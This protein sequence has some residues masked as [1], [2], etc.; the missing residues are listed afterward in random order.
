MD[1]QLENT[2]LEQS[3]QKTQTSPVVIDKD[4]PYI[5]IEEM[6][7]TPEYDEYISNMDENQTQQIDWAKADIDKYG[8]EAMAN[9]AVSRPTIAADTFDPL[10]Q[11]VPPSANVPNS[12]ERL[13]EDSLGAG[14]AELNTPALP[15]QGVVQPIISGIRQS[16]FERYYNHPEY[17]RLG[18]SPYAN[19]EEYYNSNSTAAD[20]RTRMWEQ[21]WKLTGTGFV[22]SY[23]SIADI[24]GGT[25]FAPDLASANE[26][27]DA[28]RIGNSS[29]GGL[30]GSANNFFLNSGYTFGIIGSIA[31]EEIILA[32]AAAGQGF[33]NPAS[34]AALVA[35]TARNIG[36]LFSIPGKIMDATI[37][38]RAANQA[39][40][41][42]R[43]M[44]N[45]MRNTD[46][47]K[48]FYTA[49][50]SG[51]Q[52]M[53]KIFFPETTAAIRNIKT[54]QQ[55]A[56]NLTNMAK[57]SQ[58]FGGFYRDVRSFNYAL[59]ESKLEAGLVYNERIR[60]NIQIQLKKNFGQDVTAEQMDV[61]VKNA[62][63][64]SMNTLLR[65]APLIFLTNQLVLGT[66]FG[67][68]NKSFARM[69]NQNVSS[70][71]RRMIK[72]TRA[73]GKDGLP[74]K[75]GMNMSAKLG[76]RTNV[77]EGI[78]EDAGRGLKGLWNR[79]KNV[80]VKG[81]TRALGG[82]SLRYFS[83]NLAEGL[84][85]V[86]QEAISSG[87]NHYFSSVMKDPLA[88]GVA[89]HG[90]SVS[91]GIGEQ[92]SSQG[93]E[94]FMSGFLMGGF[95]QGPQ[96]LF[97]QGLP[98]IYNKA[99]G[100]WG[101]QEMKDDIAEQNKREDDYINA[102]IDH[103]NAAWNS[104]ID[105]PTALWSPENLAFFAQKE[106]KDDQIRSV[107]ENDEFGFTDI[108]DESK[109][110]QIFSILET[111]GISEQISQYEDFQKLS[112]ENLAEAF[113]SRV[114]DIKNGKLRKE[115]ADMVTQINKTEDK[116][117]ELKDRYPNPFSPGAFKKNSREWQ[118][119]ILKQRAW[120][121][122]TFLYMFT[123]DGFEK[124]LERYNKIYAELQSDPI[125]KNMSA[126]DISVLLDV[127]SIKKEI[128]V[129]NLEISTLSIDK[130]A[131]AEEIKKKQNKI[132]ALTNFKDLVTDKKNLT[133]KGVFNRTK[134]GKLRAVFSEY[135]KTLAS[136]Q[137]T[138]AD[139]AVIDSALQ[140]IVDYGAL[141]GRAKTYYKT[142]EYLNNPERFNEIVDRT[143]AIG[144][145]QFKA[146]KTEFERML[147]DYLEVNK[148]NGLL[149]SI[150]EEGVF[151]NSQFVEV[152]LETGEATILRLPNVFSNEEGPVNKQIQPELY[153]VVM[154][155]VNA[156]EATQKTKKTEK[157]E[158]EKTETDLN[159]ENRQ[160][161]NDML[162]E[163]GVDENL[164]PSDSELYNDRLK[165]VYQKYLR[166]QAIHKSIP[167]TYK[168]FVNTEQ[169]RNFRKAYNLSRA[170]FVAN[171]KLLYSQEKD[172]LTDD[173]IA[174][175]V[176]FINWLVSNEGKTNDL[177]EDVLIK[178]EVL[179]SDITGRTE[180]IGETVNGKSVI[181]SEKNYT[182]LKEINLDPDGNDIE[183][184]TIIDSETKEQISDDLL[185]E[186]LKI[187]SPN[188]EN[189]YI[190]GLENLEEANQVLELLEKEFGGVESFVYDGVDLNFGDIVYNKKKGLGYQVLSNNDSIV[191]RGLPLMLK[192]LNAEETII[193]PKKGEF[194]DYFT[195]QDLTLEDLADSVSRLNIND[196][197]SL[198]PNVNESENKQ[199]AVARLNAIL[200][201]LTDEEVNSL[202]MVVTLEREGAPVLTGK[203]IDL[204]S[205]DNEINPRIE[206]QYSKYKIG[207]KVDE[208]NLSVQEKINAVINLRGTNKVSSDGI[209]AFINVDGYQFGKDSKLDENGNIV[210]V[211]KPENFTEKELDNLLVFPA[212]MKTLNGQQK[213]A[214]AKKNFAMNEVLLTALD[215]KMKGE[216][217][218]Q[219]VEMDLVS[220]QEYLIS[221]GITFKIQSGGTNYNDSAR[222]LNEL[223]Y[224]FADEAGNFV[225]YRLDK[226]GNTRTP[227]FF[228]NLEGSAR[229]TLRD[230]I[231]KGLKDQL[232][233]D[234]MINGTAGTVAVVLQ[235]NGKYVLVNLIASQINTSALF[236][237]VIGKA[238]QV[239][240]QIPKGKNRLEKDSADLK[241]LTTWK[242]GN[243]SQLFITTNPNLTKP[244]E[245][246]YN[247]YLDI[248]PW[249]AIEL[250]LFLGTKHGGRKIST[251]AIKKDI[252]LN[253]E[254][255]NDMITQ[256]LLD[257]FNKDQ[258][259]AETGVTIALENF[260]MHSE[261]ND[262][263]VTI[264][265]STE[266]NVAKEVSNP[267][268]MRLFT[269]SSESQA[270]ENINEITTKAQ[271]TQPTSDVGT[272]LTAGGNQ[273]LEGLVAA[274]LMTPEGSL[275]NQTAE[276][277]AGKFALENSR[278][279][280]PTEGMTEAEIGG[281][282]VFN[283]VSQG[284][285]TMR[286]VEE[287]ITRQVLAL[288][289]VDLAKNITQSSLQ[290]LY[291]K[292]EAR[293]AVIKADESLT[294]KQKLKKAKNDPEVISLLKKIED[295]SKTANKIV[296]SMTPQ[297]VEDISVFI[298]WAAK[299][300]P[301]SITIQDIALLGN[302]LKTGGRRV[303][304]FVLDLNSLAGGVDVNGTIYTGAASPFRYH[305]AFHGVYRMLLT[306]AEQKKY[307]AVARK[308][309]RAKLRAEGKNF[310]TELEK[311]KN[312]ADTYTNMSEQE[313]KD[314]YYEEYMADEFEKFKANPRS[315]NT[316]SEVK[317]LFTR[318]LDWIK[319]V[320][321]SY[322]SKQLQ[323]LFENIDSGK[324]YNASTVINQFT[325][326]IGVTLEANA[327]VPYKTI[328]Q[329][330]TLDSKGNIV[331]PKRQ[332][333]LYLDSVIADPMI[334]SMA[335]MYL[336]R[337][338]NNTDPLLL[339]SD[340]LDDLIIDFQLLLDPL[341]SRNIDK[342]EE[343]K[344]LLMQ[345]YEAISNS[346]P[347]IESQV[348]AYLNVID[349]Q[350]EEEEYNKEF[351]EQS[352]GLR[353]TEQW[354]TDASMVGGINSSPK[355]VR[356]YLAS[357]TI[358]T[359]DF[360]GNEFLTEEV[361]AEGILVQEKLIIP[362]NFA[363][364][365][366][367]LLKS[368]KNIDD[369]KL[370]LR[371]MY[372][373]GLQNPETGAV[374]SR[375]L[376]D[377]G[378]SEE[379]ILK[380][381][382]L[383][384]EMNDPFLFNSLTKAFENFRVNYLFIQR[385]NNSG[386]VL[387]YSAAQRDDIN[388][389]IDRWSQAWTQAQK[390]LKSNEDA[391]NNIIKKLDSLQAAL[392]PNRTGRDLV[393]INNDAIDYSNKIFEFTG[394]KL[395]PQ[396]ITFSLLSNIKP[397]DIK[398]SDIQSAF[399]EVHSQ[400][401]PIER[402]AISEMITLI[403]N[404]SDIFS[405]GGD[406]MNSRLV[407]LAVNNAPFDERIGLSVFKNAE[408]NLVYAHQKPTFHLR[409]VERLNSP[410]RL[411]EL[412]EE[413]YLKNNYLLNNPAFIKMSEKS[414]HK[415][416]RLAGSAVGRINST[417]DDINDN[418]SGVAS[419][420][421]YGNY[422]VQE[423]V[424]SLI[425]S[426][427]E[428][429]NTKSGKVNFVE[430]MDDSGNKTKVALSPNLIRVL[431]ASNTGDLIYLPVI[432]AITS[433]SVLTDEVLNIFTESIKT[434]FDRI[435]R[436][437]SIKDDFNRRQIVGF[438]AEEFDSE[439]GDLKEQ[440]A[441]KLHNSA[442]L[443][444][445]STK[446][447]LEN[448]A[449]RNNATFDEALV[450]LQITPEQFKISLRDI[451]EDQFDEFRTELGD[452]NIIN[453]VSS[454]IIDGLQSGYNFENSAALLNL[455][456]DINHNLKQI[457]FNDWV[458]T[459]SINEILLGDEA[460]T[461]K[462]GV[463]AIKRA[464]AQNAAT[465][466]A[467]SAITSKAH[468]I[469]HVFDKISSFV[470]EE[471]QGVSSITGNSIDRADAILYNTLKGFRY[472]EFGFGNLT[473]MQVKLLDEIKNDGQRF[474][475]P[476]KYQD[477]SIFKSRKK[478]SSEEIFG[479]NGY[480]ANGA[481]INSRKLVYFDGKTFI[482]MSA[483]T[484]IPQFTSDNVETDP[485]KPPIWVAKPNRVELHN[486]RVKL[487]LEETENKT[488]A[489]AAPRTAFKMLKQ[490]VTP[491][492]ELNNPNKFINKPSELSAKNLGLQVAN[493]S[494][495]NEI[496]DPSQIKSLVT[497]EQPDSIKVPALRNPDGTAMTV[498]Q[499]RTAYNLATSR[500][501]VLK[502]KNKRNLIFTY[503]S[504][505]DELAL[506]KKTGKL[507]PN[508]LVFL[509]YAQGG[510][511]ASQA[512]SNLLEF[513]SDKNNE[514]QYDL[515]NPITINKFESLF[516]SYL[517]KG[518]L[519]EK[520][521][522][523]SLALISDFGNKVYRRVYEFDENGLP[524]RSEI[525]RDSV[526]KKFP[527]KIQEP[528]GRDSKG[529]PTWLQVEAPV[530]G[531]VIQDRLRTGVMEF[532]SN[533]EPTGE[534]HSEG[535]MPAHF[536]EVMDLIENSGLPMPDVISKMFAI[537]IPS[538]DNHST[539][540]VK[541]VDF[542]PAIYGS[543]GMF[544]QELIEISGADFDID[545]IY[546][547]IKEWYVKNKKFVEYGKATTDEGAYT[548]YIEYVNSKVNK[549]DSIY[550]Q[551]L[552]LPSAE[553]KNSLSDSELE[554][555]T[556]AGFSENSWKAL[557]IL[558]L[559]ITKKDYLEYR[560][561]KG[562]P[563]EA[564]MNNAILDYKYALMGHD[565][566]TT[567]QDGNQAISYTPASLTI[568]ENLWDKLSADSEYLR[569]RSRE[570]N[571][572]INNIFG[573]GR[574]F[575]ANKG[576]SI[577]AVVSPNQNLSLLTEYKI[578]INDDGPLITINGVTYNTFEHLREHLTKT[579]VGERKQDIISSLITM[580]TDNAKER[581]IAKF[582]LN[583]QA[584]AAV[585]NLTA[586]S[587]PIETSILLVNIPEM[588]N[589]YTEA[590]NKKEQTDPGVETLLNNRLLYLATYL[591]EQ[592]ATNQKNDLVKVSV[593]DELLKKYLDTP[594]PDLTVAEKDKT[595]KE[596]IAE[597][598]YNRDIYSILSTILN[599]T[600]ITK[601][602]G[603]MR[604]VS[605]LTSGLGKDIAA[606]NYKKEQIDL[607]FSESAIMDLSPIY[608]SDTWQ[609]TYL[610]IFNEIYR[611]VLPATFLSASPYFSQIISTLL[612][613]VNTE[614]SQFTSDQ[615]AKIE[616]DLLSY[617]TIKGYQ[618][619]KGDGGIASFANLNN[620]LIYPY[621]SDGAL[622]SE[623]SINDVIEN[624][625]NTQAGTNNFFLNVFAIQTPATQK[626]NFTGLN[627]VLSN[628]FRSLNGMQKVDLQTSFAELYG[629]IETKGWA[630]AIINYIM[631]KDGLQPA[632]GTLLDAI[633][634]YIISDYL[635]HIETT[636]DAMRD[637][638][639]DQKMMSTFGLTFEEMQKDFIN[640]YLSS[641]V[642][643]ALLNTFYRNDIST[644][645]GDGINE[646]NG[647]LT[648]NVEKNKNLIDVEF[649]RIQSSNIA[650]G[651]TSYNTYMLSEVGNNLTPS[652][653]LEIEPTG[654]NQQWGGGFMFGPRPSYKEVRKSVPLLHSD[655]K[656]P[657]ENRVAR[658]ATQ[659]TQD[660]QRR[661][662]DAE[663]IIVTVGTAEE[664]GTKVELKGEMPQSQ[665]FVF[666]PGAIV[667][668]VTQGESATETI[669]KLANNIKNID[670]RR[671][672][673]IKS[674]LENSQL[675]KDIRVDK[676]QPKA[677]KPNMSDNNLAAIMLYGKNMSQL[678]AESLTEERREANVLAYRIL[679][680]LMFDINEITEFMDVM[681]PEY[682][683]ALTTNENPVKAFFEN[684]IFEEAEKTVNI[685]TTKPIIPST[686]PIAEQIKQQQTFVDAMQRE[687]DNA[688]EGFD[689][690]V[691]KNIKETYD[692]AVEK[693]AGLDELE[694]APSQLSMDFE[695]T[696][697]RLEAYWDEEIE[698]D[699]VK[700]AIFANNGM[701]SYI[702]M[703]AVYDEQVK[704]GMYPATEE[705]TS[706]EVF[707]EFNKCLK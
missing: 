639:S 338:A 601:F 25:P 660:L 583:K 127:D 182:V 190:P 151:L 437:S 29:R 165:D 263:V 506:S 206:R 199:D 453:E 310:N 3:I 604:A 342:S 40:K 703:K 643:N 28:M 464:K 627:Q 619:N 208:N 312:S 352:V 516:L 205:D 212:G 696:N 200:S 202:K 276:Q 24:F 236:T 231:E 505:M 144:Q 508:L 92:F 184:F 511:K 700:K 548:D 475:D 492:E 589:I 532:D 308:E 353:N 593:T 559:P 219:S 564:P 74:R 625:L 676:S 447:G 600:K 196:I 15:G 432:K 471:P 34:D 670:Q 311:L 449:N 112:D 233:W 622:T 695:E 628:S 59:S 684:D 512:S 560:K 228:T 355:A 240:T 12:F 246:K 223:D 686:L 152:F 572:D 390:K 251:T 448:I 450:E 526:F 507:T 161:V 418:I 392:E 67:G 51:K 331:E 662:A 574:A 362:V 571:I 277:S 163:M 395:S 4:Q 89:L 443:L 544:S 427:T 257:K 465:I 170:I 561:E 6:F 590:I 454:S 88:G 621:T 313:L 38:G 114:K 123:N 321:S 557:Q 527:E 673:A 411:D 103:R 274:W 359:S 317:S 46:K 482:K 554:K 267:N 428:A 207:F 386:K 158:E 284:L 602:T 249:G 599:A 167:V 637:G 275:K 596:K 518:T 458:N 101:T 316:S 23:R 540:N 273:S 90:E 287:E 430:V 325:D 523:H 702:S 70:L 677:I 68:F 43:S 96:K 293:R 414:R 299:N 214:I 568:L 456:D 146:N 478:I 394:I 688:E 509:R 107:Y 154:N 288:E 99:K 141:K 630:Q 198:Y 424:L 472:S 667:G 117:I 607:L 301:S 54:A 164:I 514:Q 349:G 690:A 562:E 629:T 499:I 149:N 168:A 191:Q 57:N 563:Y 543:V 322:N 264:I 7:N 318:I 258:A 675:M 49:A 672:M 364:V 341:A 209:F 468:G 306:P 642:N 641:N 319:S 332:G 171:H 363:E 503:D 344:R 687:L 86:S 183:F 405:D 26:F 459:K 626:D 106:L 37:A 378:V 693:L 225:I 377:I 421:T 369:P 64:A 531:I 587:V 416:I 285:N 82:A 502:Y 239:L 11:E 156:Y 77:G 538:Q 368:V 234:T 13:M 142:I 262:S 439:T 326:Q 47:A 215:E 484:L 585:V 22:S 140:K 272:E 375:F 39:F 348:Y 320:F 510:L 65:N 242:K 692:E 224:P 653:Y 633:S 586:L 491:L 393:V 616:R 422:S 496:V 232:L 300:L 419:R 671:L 134:K 137:S 1:K 400:E 632:Y 577:G 307:L 524:Y 612:K 467:A 61:I 21:F 635:D 490:D 339:R 579:I 136:E 537:R 147:R 71:G 139:E 295:E 227:K 31:M 618:H 160:E 226:K 558:G 707:M 292:L 279:N 500:R 354:D 185:L 609:S 431:E 17:A 615:R 111:G 350:V 211:I 297:D 519:A 345:A 603:N 244:G 195:L 536:K 606:V 699:P 498:G 44:V 646:K 278:R 309:V 481:M 328:S 121:H 155:L 177:I 302:N 594:I 636:N 576:A 132:K 87:V 259:E 415:I 417:E 597:F 669:S 178:L 584:L 634:P 697:P 294:E 125:F 291:D 210:N 189:V 631:V 283:V 487:E 85:E 397:K 153:K 479:E 529:E 656:S 93:F 157:Q 407:T 440:R 186:Y 245:A 493:P 425:N 413:P 361:N 611:D 517:S 289:N 304:A 620:N 522:G 220:L 665:P 148:K 94:V 60:D 75:A 179:R 221:K 122:A 296:A 58:K 451:L 477:P 203:Y 69:I 704:K 383:P 280:S 36:R 347:I 525:I 513:F 131:N 371:N 657:A 389:Q 324:Y 373:F 403:N 213:L 327:L 578:S 495:K 343:Q 55:G 581:L 8:I 204:R 434:E 644:Y 27:E 270:V 463:D 52:F 337:V 674:D 412:K 330:A 610:S 547:Q 423:F 187:I 379:T 534:R 460:V 569:E 370:M 550:N 651:F 19:N 698:N 108:S 261:R 666:A 358:S 250:Q 483:F 238:K 470:I 346:Q 486:L 357:T 401:T 80:S 680:D 241:E 113:P 105:D 116:Y 162:E 533:N 256:M 253:V 398:E 664:G 567:S 426:Y 265:E 20:D 488:I 78:V 97:F 192:A 683:A 442:S 678:Q 605:D 216:L 648:V 575:S 652:I 126:S 435:R 555:A 145:E 42:T 356:A 520:L 436:E 73:V 455:N 298:D 408:G 315:S 462:N 521:P 290:T 566:V 229:D 588:Q 658:D 119:E 402:D 329:D 591:K 305:E 645:L 570:D 303:G 469:D 654:S 109:F 18:F 351:M 335:A 706:E 41:Y 124:A 655:K 130:T 243:N 380:N 266:T 9:L 668:T 102:A 237:E 528:T 10:L 255:T 623:D 441:Y 50:N 691:L 81:G 2:S 388:S 314:T 230:N 404:D 169:G 248:A 647:K 396:F 129:L 281:A 515:N 382:P 617:I 429:V 217:L 372:F 541:I 252:L 473:P 333:F 83:A 545:K 385:E 374:V 381:D 100:K 580:A 494:N 624:L 504:A 640:G 95:V 582:G 573:K 433:D 365:Y 282:D 387:I 384:L 409:E 175:D 30:A 271:P 14:L 268:A 614:S 466:S 689:D 180:K 269:T 201:V 56:A 176:E 399:L 45:Q 608:K 457:F 340:I 360:F 685:E 565:G 366:N 143:I 235:P 110:H 166:S 16:N 135:V 138:F 98:A 32:A 598:N 172:Q 33:L 461:L 91:S 438:N 546:A 336:Q 63:S 286:I 694:R 539:M 542:L 367:G 133:K 638:G 406:G 104:N 53:G 592:D 118:A 173:Q 497:S 181:R 391:K 376:S 452:L 552:I 663:N 549:K 480:V 485:T 197:I 551:A 489:I 476:L 254:L 650:T 218:G 76:S 446:E 35:G 194:K 444:E 174:N 410:E 128:D 5:S 193:Y 474:V 159:K 79:A 188:P 659:E 247:I 556:D 62:S 681:T 553:L 682:A 501:V 420:Q 48:D 530:K 323:T 595:E 705:M 150:A 72:T 535:L 222:Q 613:S 679:N 120:Q 701:R 115:F 445:L 66:A 334:A 649:L 84:Q 260:R 661:M